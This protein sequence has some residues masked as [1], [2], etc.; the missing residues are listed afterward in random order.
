MRIGMDTGQVRMMA[1]TLRREADAID[2]H[3]ASIR[4]SVEGANWQSQAR[5]EYVSNLE[6]LLR[7]NAK[8]TQAMR[9]MAQAAERKAEQWEMLANKF[10]GPFISIGN[11]WK[12]FTDSLSNVIQKVRGIIKG[13][14]WP[15][16]ET[17]VTP[18]LIIP[19][20]FLFNKISPSWDWKKPE[21]WPKSNKSEPTAVTNKQDEFTINSRF[22]ENYKIPD[23]WSEKFNDEKELSSEIRN[24]ELRLEEMEKMGKGQSDPDVIKVSN[25]I[26]FLKNQLSNIE[27]S[28][29]LGIP[30]GK[31]PANYANGLAGCTNYLAQK[32][33]ISGFWKGG[34]M[35]AT[36]WDDNARSAGFDV[37]SRPIKGSIMV[38][39]AGNNSLMK[40]D[41]EAGHV[42]YVENVQNVEGGYMVSVS[43]G[44]VARENGKA[45]YGT[46]IP[47]KPKTFFVPT[48][49]AGINFI[50]DKNL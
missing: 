36:Y 4:A 23:K 33:D 20:V 2:G 49:A 15:K 30:G 26:S 47:L 43:H 17:F 35:N 28:I 50:Y 6:A 14:N 38:I 11:I 34:H 32:R 10:N 39:E 18:G 44:G 3:M 25:E 19:G 9:L 21:W 8:T 24:L 48:E 1:S 5:E 31:T 16:I 22:G 37:G 45:I 29:E 13:I 12:E 27:K 46:Y 7:V 41:A 40:V 42:L